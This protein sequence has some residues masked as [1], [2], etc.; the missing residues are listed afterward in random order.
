MTREQAI[1]AIFSAFRS[2]TGEFGV[3]EAEHATDMT[4]CIEA[5]R[6]LGISDDE[7]RDADDRMGYDSDFALKRFLD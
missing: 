1:D 4:R 2:M 7:M 3:S 6:A 5:L